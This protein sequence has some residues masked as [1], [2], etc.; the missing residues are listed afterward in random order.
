MRELG[1]PA[2][3]KPCV[4]CRS[5]RHHPTGKF[6]VNAG[7]KLL[8]VWLLVGCELCGRTSK[9]PVHERVHVRALDHRRLLMFEDNDPAAVREVAMDAALAGRSGYRLD[10]GGTWEL[11]TDLPFYDLEHDDPVSFEVFVRFELPAPVRVGKLLTTGFGLS[12]S[13]VRAEVDA[14]RLLLPV[15][16]DAK[17]RADFGFS[18]R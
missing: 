4:S 14:G 16:L 10:W 8:D 17:V 7:G 13:A 1:L 3:V 2:I 6:R 15:D 5:A 9:I 12:R 18:V 11:E